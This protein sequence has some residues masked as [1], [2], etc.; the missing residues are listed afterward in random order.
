MCAYYEHYYVWNSNLYHFS[1]Q[2]PF[3]TI[4]PYCFDVADI[5]GTPLMGSDTSRPQETFLG[6]S[7]NNRVEKHGP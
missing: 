3:L 6:C 1:V 2:G 4:W 5:K 7:T